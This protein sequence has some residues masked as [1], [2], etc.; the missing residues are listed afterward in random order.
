MLENCRKSCS[1][2]KVP[3]DQLQIM[4]EKKLE[5][6]EPNVDATELGVEQL[7]GTERQA[8]VEARIA[9]VTNYFETVVKVEPKYAKVVKDCKYRHENCAFWAVIGEVR[10]GVSMI[11]CM[12]ACMH[13][14][15]HLL[16]SI[17]C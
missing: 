16:F 3:I 15:F 4:I 10:Y 2:C 12:H 11:S 8:E 1:T 6:A 14:D 5:P 9:N 17:K 7:T 13:Y